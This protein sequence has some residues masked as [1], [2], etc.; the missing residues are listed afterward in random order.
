MQLS[1]LI[2]VI[3]PVRVTGSENV[4]VLDVAIDSRQVRPGHLFIA[5]PGTQVDGHTFIP[6]ATEQGAVAVVYCNPEFTIP[7][8]SNTTFIPY[9]CHRNK[10]QD[11][12]RHL[13]I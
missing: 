10:R 8:D 7:A 13:I 1:E 2:K 5:V 9:R 6:K 12:Y 3:K 4:E 11:N